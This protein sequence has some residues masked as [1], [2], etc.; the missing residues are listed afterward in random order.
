M[1]VTSDLSWYP[2]VVTTPL[3]TQCPPLLIR[4]SFTSNTYS[5]YL[6]DL[7]YI[8]GESLSRRE[9]VQRALNEDTSIDPSEDASQM[10]ILL[11]KLKEGLSLD[12]EDDTLNPNIEVDLTAV[13][14]PAKPQGPLLSVSSEILLKI[15]Y[16][17]P[18]PLL[19]L[20][21]T[22]KLQPLPQSRLTATMLLPLMS[23]TSLHSRQVKTLLQIIKDKDIVL[24]KMQDALEDSK[25]SVGNIVGGAAS[26]R[27]G[28]ERFD[29]KKWRSQLL[30]SRGE[31][32]SKPASIVKSIFGRIQKYEHQN[33]GDV[34]EWEE[35]ASHVEGLVDSTSNRFWWERIESDG[36]RK[37]QKKLKMFGS[38]VSDSESA[39]TESR[40]SDSQLTK[41]RRVYSVE[42]SRSERN[43]GQEISH[44]RKE[45]SVSKG[46]KRPSLESED[47]EFEV[48]ETPPPRFKSLA[49]IEPPTSSSSP[50]R[51]ENRSTKQWPPSHQ[52]DDDSTTEDD[53]LDINPPLRKKQTEKE[54]PVPRRISSSPEAWFHKSPTQPS[55]LPAPRNL[56]FSG[57]K[58][59]SRT[60]KPLSGSSTPSTSSPLPN[61]PKLGT[62]G[63]RV[64]I[65]RNVNKSAVQGKSPA[66]EAPEGT[67]SPQGVASD[68]DGTT[69]SENNRTPVK[70]KTGGVI[71]KVGGK[72]G[73]KVGRKIEGKIGTPNGEKATIT[74]DGRTIKDAASWRA[75]NMPM[76]ETPSEK[77]G[78]K[79]KGEAQKERAPKREPT[80]NPMDEEVAD[81]KR[82]QLQQ[83]LEAKQK[84]PVKKKRKF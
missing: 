80:V 28:L 25:L 50:P 62:V 19:P 67:P 58:T 42:G 37:E 52:G 27:R 20:V 63:R 15:T 38:D 18:E 5:I 84:A 35:A 56:S 46:K 51:K 74:D 54:L 24:E 11:Q 61:S 33:Y 16:Q 7:T 75:N 68:D 29:E 55:P 1:S 79:Q 8:W 47:D 70:H 40:R 32:S 12:D 59:V 57:D 76:N 2:L 34:H 22:F 53:D 23:L 66:R 31:A 78:F 17:L 82:R 73:G 26:R 49:N 39:R 77:N 30:E 21:W 14:R 41:H 9:I 4:R 71:G 13:P 81:M 65:I 6:T 44:A 64:G 10:R 43:T 3:P 83:E 69:G 72:I 60:S 45:G 48:Q 36:K